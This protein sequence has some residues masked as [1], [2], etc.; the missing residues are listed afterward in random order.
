MKAV[1][2]NKFEISVEKDK[3]FILGTIDADLNTAYEIQ[4]WISKK[5]QEMEQNERKKLPFWKRVL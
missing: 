3:L 4:S 1:W 2:E 5:I